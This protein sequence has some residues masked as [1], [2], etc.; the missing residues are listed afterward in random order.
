MSRAVEVAAACG[1]EA[2][3]AAE[4]EAYET[5]VDDKGFMGW[6]LEECGHE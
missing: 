2:Q 1:R 6:W 3:T 4:W 5:W